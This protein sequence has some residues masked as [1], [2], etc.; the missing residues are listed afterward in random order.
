MGLLFML[1]EGTTE[2]PPTSII[3][4]VKI[5]N[6]S[7]APLDR[8]TEYICVIPVVISELKLS[9]V[10]MQ[11]FLANLMISTDNPA[12]QDRPEALQSYWCE[13]RQRHADQWCDQRIG[14]GSGASIVRSRGKHRCR[15]G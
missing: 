2:A 15:E 14:A 6:V 4:I 7:S 10:K 12:L 13:L 1:Q 5:A 11:I 9:D 3:K 8:R